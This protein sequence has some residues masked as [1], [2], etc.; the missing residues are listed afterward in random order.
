M[1][2]APLPSF[3]ITKKYSDVFLNKRNIF[4]SVKKVEKTNQTRVLLILNLIFNIF[5]SQFY[6]PES[7]KI[8]H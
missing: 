7:L 5:P 4:K 3:T 8:C 1:K 6:D 2:E